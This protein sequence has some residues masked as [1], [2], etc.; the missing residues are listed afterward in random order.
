MTRQGFDKWTPTDGRK[1]AVV[2]EEDF[3]PLRAPAPS[4]VPPVLEESRAARKPTLR[5]I[6][7]DMLDRSLGFAPENG[8]PGYRK[9]DGEWFY[10]ARWL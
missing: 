6:V 9:I 4:S 10:S 3:V 2:G 1:F 7:N 8:A 5:V